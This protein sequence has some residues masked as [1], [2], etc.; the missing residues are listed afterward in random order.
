MKIEKI[1]LTKGT[2]FY[3]I[4]HLLSKEVSEKGPIMFVDENDNP[5]SI[6]MGMSNIRPEEDWLSDFPLIN[7]IWVHTKSN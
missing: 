5:L 3:T 2:S 4:I 7:M 1:K 6:L